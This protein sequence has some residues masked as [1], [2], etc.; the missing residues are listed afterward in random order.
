MK[1]CNVPVGCRFNKL[2]IPF[3]PQLSISLFFHWYCSIFISRPIECYVCLRASLVCCLVFHAL[4]HWLQW[5]IWLKTNSKNQA[6]NT[7][8]LQWL[9]HFTGLIYPKVLSLKYLYIQSIFYF[10]L[11][12]AIAIASS[13]SSIDYCFSFKCDRF[14]SSS[15]NIFLLA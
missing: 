3:P 14:F 4:R 7:V 12:A 6:S 10:H 1:I 5:Y 11:P 13:Q 2:L 9:I 8:Y 15:L